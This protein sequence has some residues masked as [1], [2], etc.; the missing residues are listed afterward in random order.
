MAAAVGLVLAAVLGELAVRTF[1]PSQVFFPYRALYARS[2]HADVGY[3]LRPDFDGFALGAPLRT[4]NL[5]F[6]G[7]DWLPAKPKGTLRVALLGDSHAFGFGVAYEKSV[8]YLLARGLERRLG[9]RCELL[10]FGVPGYDTSQE[11]ATLERHALALDPDL[12]VVLPCSNDHEGRLYAGPDGLLHSEPTAEDAPVEHGFWLGGAATPGLLRRSRLVL[13]L[14]LLWRRWRLR[15][16]QERLRA[17]DLGVSSWMGAFQGSPDDPVPEPF[18][19]RV[20]VPLRRIVE[21]CRER[22]IP[23]VLAG[24][25]EFQEYRII[26]HRLARD[27]D[28]PMVELLMSF[29]E[30]RDWEDVVEKFGLGWNDHLGPEAHRRW[31]EAILATMERKGVLARLQ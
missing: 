14:E 19:S 25:A 15:S 6:R 18:R 29:P 2:P 16:R 8:G 22:G 1:V 5:G 9:R 24:L 12:V 28:V 23:V 10:N 21:R 3:T 27:F 20:L 4:N 31:A 17:Q 30:A 7:P 11:L 13:Y 26:F